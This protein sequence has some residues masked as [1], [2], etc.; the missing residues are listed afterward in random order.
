MKFVIKIFFGLIL[1][2]S[3][4]S[5]AQISEKLLSPQ[6]AF[7]MIMR[8]LSLYIQK[9]ELK[10]PVI[11]LTTDKSVRSFGSNDRPV[12]EIFTQKITRVITGDTIDEI[13]TFSNGGRRSEAMI[14]HRRGN[15]AGGN[16]TPTPNEDL[17]EF[18]FPNP[19][20]A[21]EYY[22]QFKRGPVTFAF[23]NS[24]NGILA[25]FKFDEFRIMI[26]DYS[27]PNKAVR[28]YEASTRSRGG[29]GLLETVSIRSLEDRWEARYFAPIHG[30]STEPI[31]PPEFFSVYGG[32]IQG[33]LSSIGPQ[34]IQHLTGEA[35]WPKDN[36]N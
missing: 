5:R 25:E 29:S 14:I 18:K 6:T 11:L 31:D 22:L 15:P 26:R 13:M 35:G 17:L 16:P 2:C 19:D 34:I 4:I 7:Q 28:Q 12:H 33:V 27:E 10:Y 24:N 32:W 3:S 20:T 1:I 36:P 23:R 8:S 21:I 30:K 9:V